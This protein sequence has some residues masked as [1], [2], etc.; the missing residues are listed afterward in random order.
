MIRLHPLCRLSLLVFI[1]ASCAPS[2][3]LEV[4]DRTPAL[5]TPPGLTETPG[6]EVARAIAIPSVTVTVKPKPNDVMIAE[7]PFLETTPPIN[8]IPEVTVSVTRAPEPQKRLR[9]EGSPDVIVFG[10]AGHCGPFCN[11]RDTWSYLNAATT[12]TGYIETAQAVMSVLERQGY[13]VA[14][15]DVSSFVKAHES[16]IS[17][18][19]EHGLLEA[20]AYLD[21]I[22]ANWIENVENPT[23]VILLAHSHGTV[24]ATLLAINNL[25]VTFDY[26]IYLDGICWQFW[27]FHK[28]HIRSAYKELGQSLP[29]PLREGDPCTFLNIPGQQKFQDINDV[30]PANAIYGLEVKS[31]LNVFALNIVRDDD[32]NVRMN[33]SRD[34][35]WTIETQ[36][37]H[38]DVNNR[39]GDAMNWIEEMMLTLGMPDHERFSMEQFVLPPAP[40]GFDYSE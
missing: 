29:Y 38:S 17:K 9:P 3:Q 4:P 22:K 27:G 30:V 18:E 11:V 7:S 24:W 13:S 8:V 34:F 1:L 20:Q 5:A 31:P 10:F 2:T 40:E 19:T 15:F 37:G 21:D 39:Y 6:E 12:D 14:Y 25:D 23:K 28:N 32:T 26:F 16:S 36:Q 33:G 35:I